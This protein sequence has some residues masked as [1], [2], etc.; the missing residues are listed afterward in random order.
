[1]SKS[2]HTH[3]QFSSVQAAYAGFIHLLI[4]GGT[5]TYH[6]SAILGLCCLLLTCLSTGVTALGWRALCRS[7]RGPFHQPTPP[8]LPPAFPRIRD[9]PTSGLYLWGAGL[10]CWGSENRFL[11]SGDS[12]L[13]CVGSSNRFLPSPGKSYLEYRGSRNRFLPSR[14]SHT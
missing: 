6:V 11:P 2:P 5:K 3:V 12:Y 7:S 8:S 10:E 9:P 13:E 14:V 4:S 1:M